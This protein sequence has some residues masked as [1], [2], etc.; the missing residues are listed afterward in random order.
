MAFANPRGLPLPTAKR[1]FLVLCAL[2]VWVT[3]GFQLHFFMIWA[4]NHQFTVLGGI[5]SFFSFFT[6]L[7]NILAGISLIMAARNT[8]PGALRRNSSLFAATALYLC[9]AGIVFNL[10]LSDTVPKTH[11]AY[12]VNVLLHDVIPALFFSFWLFIVP[13]AHLGKRHL[14]WWMVFP[15]AYFAHVMLRG[16]LIEHYPYAFFNTILLDYPTVLL[17]GLEMLVGFLLLGLLLVG[18]DR[19]KRR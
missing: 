18:I 19:I 16:W 2:L 4:K 9:M 12:P 7:S 1:V 10:E 11:P 17:N 3:L 14:L 8:S 5:W 13:R 15:V 6:N